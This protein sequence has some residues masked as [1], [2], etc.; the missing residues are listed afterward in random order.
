M[1]WGS[2]SACWSPH[3]FG[4]ISGGGG[5]GEGSQ[6]SV[7]LSHKSLYLHGRESHQPGTRICLGLGFPYWAYF[8]PANV[9]GAVIRQVLFVV[10]RPN[11]PHQTA[12]VGH[13]GDDLIAATAVYV[14]A[15]IAPF[16]IT[17]LWQAGPGQA[18][19]LSSFHAV[20][21]STFFSTP[22]TVSLIT[23]M[24]LQTCFLLYLSSSQQPLTLAT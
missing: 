9:F 19:G 24:F 5:R 18:S 2:L 16:D 7:L 20:R 6:P 8:A 13:V 12:R 17:S 14:G 22:F 1:N 4:V 11:C 21:A 23:L 15:A 10:E 3:C